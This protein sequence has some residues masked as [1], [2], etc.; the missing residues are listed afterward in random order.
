MRSPYCLKSCKLPR[1]TP[2]AAQPARFTRSENY[3]AGNLLAK[4]LVK[5][6]PRL[7]RPGSSIPVECLNLLP[8]SV[9]LGQH[10]RHAQ[11][12]TVCYFQSK[13]PD[14]YAVQLRSC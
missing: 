5:A 2:A 8:Y 1:Q 13:A 9:E 12:L 7:L 10:V 11:V 6:L 3:D 14:K 4:S